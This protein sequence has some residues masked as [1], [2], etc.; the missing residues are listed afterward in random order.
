MILHIISYMILHIIYDIICNII[1][2]FFGHEKKR[3]KKTKK[4]IFV[5]NISINL[6]IER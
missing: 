1:Y 2:D 3:E 6:S 5:E 4:K